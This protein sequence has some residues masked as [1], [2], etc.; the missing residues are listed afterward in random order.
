MKFKE[1]CVCAAIGPLLLFFCS[2]T[3]FF[4]C[5]R[6][7][8]IYGNLRPRRRREKRNETVL[9]RTG[10]AQ[11]FFP[12]RVERKQFPDRRANVWGSFS[13]SSSSSTSPTFFLSLSLSLSHSVLFPP[14]CFFVDCVAEGY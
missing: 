14:F 13:S 6:G 8:N 4:V 5:G 3:S 7:D 1:D 2:F 11:G 10:I 9:S 12:T